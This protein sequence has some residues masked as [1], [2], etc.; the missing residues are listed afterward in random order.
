[1]LKPFD[2]ASKGRSQPQ[3]RPQ[4]AACAIRDDD[5]PPGPHH[6]AQG[7]EKLDVTLGHS[8][9]PIE[10]CDS[11]FIQMINHVVHDH[12]VEL[13]SCEGKIPQA[14]SMSL[15]LFESK[16]FHISAEYIQ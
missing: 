1:M 8:I 3:A 10:R 16:R 2:R 13:H 6:G 4:I 5:S 11:F 7:L 12:D 9:V 15:D 14:A